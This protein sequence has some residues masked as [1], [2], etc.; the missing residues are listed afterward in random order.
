MGAFISIPPSQ[1]AT[2]A[3]KTT[4]NAYTYPSENGAKREVVLTADGK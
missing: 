2:R 3:K 1:T 4:A